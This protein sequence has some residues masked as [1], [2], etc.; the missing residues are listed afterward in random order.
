MVNANVARFGMLSIVKC[1]Q[2]A[3]RGVGKLGTIE[4]AKATACSCL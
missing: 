2:A 3:V 1:G 4:F